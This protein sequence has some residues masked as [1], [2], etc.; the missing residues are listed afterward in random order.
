MAE[1]FFISIIT[2]V[3]SGVLAGLILRFLPNNEKPHE[4]PKPSK[5]LKIIMIALIIGFTVSAVS[6]FVFRSPDYE[7]DIPIT[8]ITFDMTSMYL[9]VGS[10]ETVTAII[11]PPNAS[12]QTIAW[13][14][15]DSSVVDV[16]SIGV[17]TAMSEGTAIITATATTG[18][19]A[20]CSVTV[21]E[22]F[23]P[24]EYVPNM[25]I[26]SI[27]GITLVLPNYAHPENATN[28][29]IEWSIENAGGT[30][31]SIIGNELNATSSG[32]VMIRATVINGE[33]ATTDFTQLFDITIRTAI[34]TGAAGN[35]ITWTFDADSGILSFIGTGVMWDWERRNAPWSAYVS[36][37]ETVIIGNGITRVGNHS[38]S[39]H[40]NLHDVYISNSV[41]YIGLSAFMSSGL[42][43]VSMP[44][45]T[46]IEMAA[47]AFNRQLISVS[48]PNVVR[49]DNQ[50]F[51]NTNSLTNVN[52]PNTLLRI[53]WYAFGSG[54]LT[55]T[56]V[57]PANVE[58][59]GSAPFGGLGGTANSQLTDIVTP[60]GSS[61]FV[62]IEGVLFNRDVTR[63]HSYPAGRIGTHY[64]IPISVTHITR[65]AFINAVNLTS[66]IIRSNDIVFDGNVFRYYDGHSI[67]I[68]APIGSTAHDYAISNGH[69]FVPLDA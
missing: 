12:N 24:V 33:T 23:I 54:N 49:I 11:T 35:N 55:G 15:S 36:Y 68:T 7:S 9:Y 58:Y 26:E 40:Y 38:F 37:V 16:N 48:M 5:S 4:S 10:T 17:I 61:Y 18:V 19:S 30:N 60:A 28:R 34:V 42:T 51:S 1:V 52:F 31:S 6:Y 56:V 25:P 22:L 45:V 32:T 57:I 14:S 59:I 53:D 8:A 39:D 41:T 66:V 29:F 13:S 3:I 69:H 20:N 43:S 50:A 44:N 63:L 2:G 46:H 21:K 47:F 67:T 27:V 65:G 62:S 64:E